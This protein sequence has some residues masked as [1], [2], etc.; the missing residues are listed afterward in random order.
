MIVAKARLADESD[1]CIDLD[2][3]KSLFRPTL[4]W[5]GTIYS[6]GFFCSINFDPSICPS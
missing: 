1:F 5:V 4:V 6:N 2:K 3:F